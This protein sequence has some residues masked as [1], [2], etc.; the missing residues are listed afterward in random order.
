M[1]RGQ[2]PV[3]PGDTEAAEG[4]LGEGTSGGAATDPGAG[5]G[6]TGPEAGGTT[7]RRGSRR[8]RRLVALGIAGAVAGAWWVG[9]HSPLT[10]VE[11]VVVDGPRGIPAQSIR[12][13][14]G[15]SPADHVPGVDAEA[16]RLGIMTQIPAVADVR[17]SRSLPHT[18]R[19]EVVARTPL[20]AVAS[21]KGFYVMDAD[22]VVYDKVARATGMP[23]IKARG[24]VGRATARGVLVSLPKKLRAKVVR[25]DAGTRDDVTLTLKGGATVRWGNAQDAEL[26]ARVLAGLMAVKATH[27]DVSAPLLPTTRGG[28]T[29]PEPGTG[30]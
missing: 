16:V 6:V 22:G 28:R 3:T 23:V 14:S 4:P 1:S 13:A 30:Q 11:H 26:K 10:L 5:P 17:V 25:V 18:I 19:L 21:G 12:M 29:G 8:R 2:A 20:A 15:I 27:Y 7:Q 9:W 24:D